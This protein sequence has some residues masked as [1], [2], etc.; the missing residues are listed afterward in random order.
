MTIYSIDYKESFSNLYSW[1]ND[2]QLLSYPDVKIFLILNKLDLENIREVSSDEGKRYVNE[3]N[4]Y[5]NETSAKT[6]LN[7]KE[8][9]I[10]A[11]KVL[12]LDYLIYKNKI[13]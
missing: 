11:A 12:Y 7:A 9:F 10:Q 3:H 4:V 5:F 8:V 13:W 1:L 6:G 2:L